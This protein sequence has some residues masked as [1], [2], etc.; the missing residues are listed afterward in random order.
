MGR[1][2]R[3]RDRRHPRGPGRACR[4]RARGD[5]AEHTGG[6]GRRGWPPPPV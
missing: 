6:D 4:P 3:I 1:D 5:P 2:Y